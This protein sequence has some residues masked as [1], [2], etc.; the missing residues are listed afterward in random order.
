MSVGGEIG[1][2]ESVSLKGK[3]RERARASNVRAPKYE[4]LS[5][6]IYP[7]MMLL[8]LLL[9]RYSL[10]AVLTSLAE[11]WDNIYIEVVQA[12]VREES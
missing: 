12:S 11:V 4:T 7:V 2:R 3:A 1:F 10:L 5:A 8:F 6:R 9:S